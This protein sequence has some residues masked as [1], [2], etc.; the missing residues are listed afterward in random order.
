MCVL[1]PDWLYTI[2]NQSPSWHISRTVQN[3]LQNS[4]V[5]TTN[6]NPNSNPSLAVLRWSALYTCMFAGFLPNKPLSRG[7]CQPSQTNMDMLQEGRSYGAVGRHYGIQRY[8]TYSSSEV[9]TLWIFQIISVLLVFSCMCHLVLSEL[10]A[11]R[12]VLRTHLV[13]SQTSSRTLTTHAPADLQW[14]REIST[15]WFS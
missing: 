8:W 9:W 6:P 4:T 15:N 10:W 13:S 7:R 3:G 1:H 2:V 5:H 11:R 12:S 14:L